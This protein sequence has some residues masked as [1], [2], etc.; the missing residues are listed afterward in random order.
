MVEIGQL[1]VKLA[2]RD[3]GKECLIIKKLDNSFVMI[4]GATRR[5][6][7]NIKHLQLSTT[8]AKIKEDA[9]HEEV[10]KALSL[11][12]IIVKEKK[13]IK[14][15]KIETAKKPKKKL[16]NKKPKEKKTSKK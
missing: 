4:D 6:K 11:L 3:A 7:C 16:L 2:G 10:I 14:K 12:G 1:C 5:K 15:E 8:I 13:K 9:S